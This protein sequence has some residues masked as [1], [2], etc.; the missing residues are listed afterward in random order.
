MK[1]KLTKQEFIHHIFLE[2]ENAG[3]D[4]IIR[5]SVKLNMPIQQ[6]L[7]LTKHN[8]SRIIYIEQHYQDYLE[9]KSLNAIFDE[10]TETEGEELLVMKELTKHDIGDWE[11]MKVHIRSRVCSAAENQELIESN[12]YP[13][14][15]FL[16]LVETFF[17]Q[18]EDDSEMALAV[19]TALMEIWEVSVDDLSEVAKQNIP[20]KMYTVGSL[21]NITGDSMHDIEE[22]EFLDEDMLILKLKRNQLYGATGITNTSLLMKL[23]HRLKSRGFYILPCSVHELI[24]VP[25]AQAVAEEYEYLKKIVREANRTVVNITDRLSDNVYYFD[26]SAVSMLI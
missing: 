3:F 24:L 6:T 25:T 2:L 8:P 7:V 19:N 1:R 4:P 15:K 21:N 22:T 10:I 18:F 14:R 26:G 11:S 16:D 12:H 17:L 5:N 23:Y 13:Y 20:T 9:G